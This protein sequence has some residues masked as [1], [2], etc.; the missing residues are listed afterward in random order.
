MEKGQSFITV[1]ML[2]KESGWVWVSAYP[3]D[4][5]NSGE[6]VQNCFAQLEAEKVHGF[7]PRDHYRIG[8]FK[9]GSP[10]LS[11]QDMHK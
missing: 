1:E 4:K 3:L 10:E 7:Y 11:T 2:S 6:M 8:F 5:E 9:V